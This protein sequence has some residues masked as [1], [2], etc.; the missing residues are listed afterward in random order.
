MS[1]LFREIE[2]GLK[3]AIEIEQGNI[4][5]NKREDMPAPTY[6]SEAINIDEL[7]DDL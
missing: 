3:E 7:D 5:L 4:L 6:V 1:D 2:Q